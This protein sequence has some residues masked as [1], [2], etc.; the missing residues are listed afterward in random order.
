MGRRQA[1]Q[2]RL[3]RAMMAHPALVA[4]EGPFDSHIGCLETERVRDEV[5]D[6]LGDAIADEMSLPFIGKYLCD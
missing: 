1:G 5:V 3:V 6:D 2:E 4:G